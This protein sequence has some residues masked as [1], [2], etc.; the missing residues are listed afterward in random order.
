MIF[1][2]DRVKSNSKF[3]TSLRFLSPEIFRSGPAVIVYNE[4]GHRIEDDDIDVYPEDDQSALNGGR[5]GRRSEPVSRSRTPVDPYYPPG[6]SSRRTS[7]VGTPDVMRIE[8][9]APKGY[10][11]S[12]T[13]SARSAAYSTR[14]IPRGSDGE[15]T[16]SDSERKKGKD[17]EREYGAEDRDRGFTPSR[18]A[19]PGDRNRSSIYGAPSIAKVAS[20]NG[21]GQAPEMLSSGWV[22]NPSVGHPSS[23]SPSIKQPHS[24]ST[25]IY[26]G[27]GGHLDQSTPQDFASP[28]KSAVDE[29]RHSHLWGAPSA[30]QSAALD[31]IL[32]RPSSPYVDRPKSPY[33]QDNNTFDRPKSPSVVEPAARS[34][35]PFVHDHNNTFDRPKS[36]YVVEPAQKSSSPFVHDQSAIGRSASPFVDRPKSGVEG[37]FF[38]NNDG[39]HS[40]NFG[41]RNPAI[42]GNDVPPAIFGNDGPPAIF[43]NDRPPSMFGDSG[44]AA[45]DGGPALF[46]EPPASVF[47]ETAVADDGWGFQATAPTVASTPTTTKSG[48]SKRKGSA[49]PS[50][51]VA[52][53]ASGLASRNSPSFGA[54]KSPFGR[55]SDFATLEEPVVAAAGTSSPNTGLWGSKAP[56]PFEKKEKGLSPLN[57]ASQIDNEPPAANDTLGWDFSGNPGGGSGGGGDG[58]GNVNMDDSYHQEARIPSRTPTRAP[59][60]VPPVHTASPVPPP[61]APVEDPVAEPTFQETS[62]AKKKKKK[63][64]TPVTKSPAVLAQEV[65]EKEEEER[66]KAE[67]A[68]QA[69]AEKNANE[70]KERLEKEEAERRAQEE[71]RQREEGERA[72]KESENLEADRLA[73]V[74]A[75]TERQEAEKA[76]VTTSPSIFGNNTPMFSSGGLLSSSSLNPPDKPWISTDTG[77]GDDGWGSWGAAPTTTTKKKKGSKATTP[78]TPKPSMFGSTGWGTFGSGIGDSSSPALVPSPKPSPKPLAAELPSSQDHG[79]FDFNSSGPNL[80]FGGFDSTQQNSKGLSRAP[81]PAPAAN[82]PLADSGGDPLDITSPIADGGEPEAGPLTG[83]G[84]GEKGD[85]EGTF[86]ASSKKKKKKKGGPGEPSREATPPATPQ[87]EAA[88][89]TVAE[90]ITEPLVEP[91]TEPTT[92]GG[93]GKKKKKKK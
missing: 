25:S 41:D 32:D 61:P 31:A 28:P 26:G 18:S 72:R 59:S 51:G 63:G 71:E 85:D 35:S 9:S 92:A 91:T 8:H 82:D 27:G 40:A 13:P 69:E 57:P 73:A 29:H 2:F 49:A 6:G 54:N 47:G 67:A 81:S 50:P 76:Q 53:P 3:S 22:A 60:P 15:R 86:A 52:T 79:I 34:S 21:G 38:G 48:K 30:P 62:T 74:M 12:I 37:S 90:P 36:P 65:A 17:R 88:A 44:P 23:R 66:K 5:S 93:G 87:D 10:S 4:R 14:D 45:N 68:K 43:G 83:E 89:E 11:P 64:T 39:P 24:R 7:N 46:G 84:G 70:E 77:G 1:V 58:W 78:V 20:S 56:S 75:E 42:F 33:A 19:T 80:S 55:Q 16:G